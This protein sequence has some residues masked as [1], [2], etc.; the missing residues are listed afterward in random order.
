MN[1]EVK[2]LEQQLKDN[3]DLV[4]RRDLA[5]RLSQN[6][7]FRKLI[8]E[9]FCVTDTARLVGQSA[10][11][12]LDALQRADALNMAQASGH[13]KRYL[14]MM[15]TMGNTAARDIPAVEEALVDARN[16]EDAE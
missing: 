12:A 7:D 6:S 9:D 5:L 11:P 4:A 2:G 8:L 10:D 1:D 16:E 15:V 14:S 13:L 3:K